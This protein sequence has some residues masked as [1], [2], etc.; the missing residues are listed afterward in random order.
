V[1]PRSPFTLSLPGLTGQSRYFR[2]T[3]IGRYPVSKNFFFFSLGFVPPGYKAHCAGAVNS[4]CGLRQF[5]CLSL[6]NAKSHNVSVIVAYCIPIQ[7]PIICI[8]YSGS[9]KLITFPYENLLK[10]SSIFSILSQPSCV[11]ETLYKN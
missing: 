6:H 3:G 9:R 1:I 8:R 5:G 10:Q 4:P 11:F 2:H 7:L